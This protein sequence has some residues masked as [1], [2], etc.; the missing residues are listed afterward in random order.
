M[1]TLTIVL[2]CTMLSAFAAAQ[3]G[4][5]F[6]IKWNEEYFSFTENGQERL[7]PQCNSCDQVEETGYAPYYL[8]KLTLGKDISVNNV[9][10]NIVA[11][12]D[13]VA[14]GKTFSTGIPSSVESG[15]EWLVKEERGR[16]VLLYR[17]PAAIKKSGNSVQLV[18]RFKLNID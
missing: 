15:F 16:Q 10:L 4:G 18:S 2:L 17:F 11:Y 5:D 9:S 6:G 7:S 8:G 1:R 14:K 3:N 12:A 13:R